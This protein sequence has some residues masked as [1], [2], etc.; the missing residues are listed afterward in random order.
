MA[1]L[2]HKHKDN[3]I[4]NCLAFMREVG[5]VTDNNINYY[6]P[7]MDKYEWL[8][9]I[10]ADNDIRVVNDIYIADNE[11]KICTTNAETVKTLKEFKAKLSKAIERSKQLTVY[12]RKRTIDKDFD[13]DDE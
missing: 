10:W 12:L 11:C 9:V 1:K 7:M 8:V 4:K 6:S 2:K 13:K 3:F 5:L